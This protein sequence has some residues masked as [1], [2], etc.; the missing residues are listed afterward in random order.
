MYLASV[1]P[2]QLI[3]RKAI[4]NQP[5][6]ETLREVNDFGIRIVFLTT[7]G[8]CHPLHWHNEIEILYPL[9]G[10]TTLVLEGKKRILPNRHVIVIESCQVHGTY[11]PRKTS[12]YLCIQLSREYLK[13]TIPQIDQYR[14]RCIPSEITQEQLPQYQ[15]ICDLLAD[16]TRL[17]ISDTP[18][19]SLEASGIVIQV[20]SRL[21]R[22][23][24]TNYIPENSQQD[25]ATIERLR[26]V[27]EYV[28][29][30]YQEHISL[31]DACDLLGIGKEYF[32]RFF[33]KNM[34]ISFL[35]YSNEVRLNHIYQG[36][37]HTDIPVAELMEENGFTNQKLFNQSFKKLYGCTP[38]EVRRKTGT[39]SSG[40]SAK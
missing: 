8:G 35:Q 18:F 33:K 26:T 12:M 30:H 14:I 17:Y 25:A 11:V 32:C 36:L 19:F 15:E 37:E 38:S 23:F 28:E 21:L 34:G 31:Q 4:M 9:N 39:E 22:H 6:Y 7:P 20:L 16:L 3:E 27:I 24:S 29:N 5:Y 2:L 13:N 10:E 1:K 40:I